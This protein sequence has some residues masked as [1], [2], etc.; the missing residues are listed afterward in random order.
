MRPKS[1]LLDLPSTH[2]VV[3]HLHNEFVHWMGKL[4]AEIKVLNI[5]HRILEQY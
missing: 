1:T 2:D 5:L 3:N 4:E